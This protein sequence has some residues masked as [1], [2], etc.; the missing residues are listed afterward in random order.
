MYYQNRKA[1]PRRASNKYGKRN[2]LHTVIQ[3]VFYGLINFE[4]NRFYSFLGQYCFDI[5][6]VVHDSCVIYADP[7]KFW[8]T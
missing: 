7:G 2:E 1:I 4:L 8:E 5:L 3:L 6:F